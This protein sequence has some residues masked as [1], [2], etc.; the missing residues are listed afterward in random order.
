MGSAY[1]VATSGQT[2]FHMLLW[3]RCVC[4]LAMGMASTLLPLYVSEISDKKTRGTLLSFCNLNISNGIFAISVLGVGVPHVGGFWAIMCFIASALGVAV[5]LVIVM[6]PETPTYLA[7]SGSY[8]EAHRSL[9]WL[10]GNSWDEGM[11]QRE[12][13]S[14][15]DTNLV[16]TGQ[17][18]ESGS[19]SGSG[20][21]SG[22]RCACCSSCAHAPHRR[23][24]MLGIF[25]VA[26]FALR[27]ALGLGLG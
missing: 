14:L 1:Y 8:D 10:H 20:S 23:P 16:A 13:R 24:A 15:S 21:N 9:V 17:A 27:C 11:R 3:G 18:A 4:G 26:S 6:Y 22:C 19:G 2:G 5:A 12:I 7:R 25:V